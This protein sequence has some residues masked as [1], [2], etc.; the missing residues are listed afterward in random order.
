MS[1]ENPHGLRLWNSVSNSAALWISLQHYK[2]LWN[3]LGLC[4][5]TTRSTFPSFSYSNSLA[6]AISAR[7][8]PNAQAKCYQTWTDCKIPSELVVKLHCWS[9][10]T[11]ISVLWI[12]TR[13][14]WIKVPI[15]CPSPLHTNSTGEPQNGRV[16]FTAVFLHYLCQLWEKNISGSYIIQLVP[17]SCAFYNSY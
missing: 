7:G 5:V 8:S 13:A 6:C 11:C 16:G 15:F 1:T 4:W 3:M 12:Q 9:M 17:P 14:Q 2:W 10:R